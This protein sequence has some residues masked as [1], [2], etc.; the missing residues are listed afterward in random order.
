MQRW[1]FPRFVRVARRPRRAKPSIFAVDAAGA[2]VPSGICAFTLP[3]HRPSASLTILPA[4][5]FEGSEACP[6]E[7]GTLARPRPTALFAPPTSPAVDS[8]SV[9]IPGQLAREPRNPE[10][11]WAGSKDL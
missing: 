5:S 4:L 1:A 7:E 3:A 6:P 9:T 8:L 11:R 2:V 10:R